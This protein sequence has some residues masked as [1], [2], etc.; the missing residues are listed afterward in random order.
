MLDEQEEEKGQ[1][2][3]RERERERESTDKVV[4]V[5]MTFEHRYFLGSTI[6]PFSPRSP[7]STARRCTERAMRGASS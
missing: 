1:N 4:A 3:E 2:R 7:T 5:A 6:R